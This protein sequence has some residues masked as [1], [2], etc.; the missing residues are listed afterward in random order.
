MIVLQIN[1]TANS[2]SHG[3]IAAGIG[4]QLIQGGHKSYIAYGR[5]GYECGS[6]LIKTGDKFDQGL[7]Y[8]KSRLIDRHG[9]GSGYSTSRLV[10]KIQRIEPDV[11]HLHNLHGYY[12]NVAV[13]FRFLKKWGKPVIWT[14]HDNWPITGHCSYF[15]HMNCFKWRTGC[16]KCPNIR[17]YPG[18]WGI[19][20]SQSNFY[21][22]KE[23]FTGIGNMVLVSPSE[24]L[25]NYLRQSFLAEYDIKVINNGVDVGSFRPVSDILVRKQY[26]LQKKYILGVANIWDARKGLKDFIKL[27]SKL[28]RNTDIVLVGLSQK[29]IDSLDCGIIGISRTESIEDLAAL[30]SG[31]EAFVNPTYLDNFPLVNIEAL[32]CG[33]PV[34]TYETGGSHE[35]I[36][37]FSG[38]GVKKGNNDALY[39]AVV[40]VLY[41]AD[42]YNALSCRRRAIELYS[43]ENRYNDYVD[44]YADRIRIHGN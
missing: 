6:E 34:I 23:L 3:R 10:R 38:L 35:S 30:Y 1:T 21:E 4:K 43:A 5:T 27:R 31:A 26:S 19:D 41:N 12:L 2:A 25:A 13:L 29:Q 24:W 16:F 42:R 8:L 17:G 40:S 39:D 28:D 20:N 33:T 18:S 7:H 32:A 14:F 9:F 36:G 44:L 11:V 37:S 22:K 15:E